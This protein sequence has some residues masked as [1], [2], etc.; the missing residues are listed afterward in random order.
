A[1][2]D[3]GG[4]QAIAPGKLEDSEAWQ[5]IVSDDPGDLMPPPESHLALTDEQKQLLRRWIEEG[6]E[7]EGHWAFQTPERPDLPE[8]AS[9]AEWIRN[10]IDAFVLAQLAEEGMA[11]SP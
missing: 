7:Y 8:T 2:A 4:Y 6:A 5:R 1:T 3:L 9:A 10:E 11:P